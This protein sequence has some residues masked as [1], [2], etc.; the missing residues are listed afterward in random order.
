MSYFRYFMIFVIIIELM[1]SYTIIGSAYIG[2]KQKRVK[3]S[4]I[5]L[6]AIFMSGILLLALGVA[7]FL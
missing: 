5:P 6:L 2:Y 7:V 3:F 1:M 4:A